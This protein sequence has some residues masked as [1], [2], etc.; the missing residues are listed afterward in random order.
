VKL[1][2]R[3]LERVEAAFTFLGINEVE[4]VLGDVTD[5]ISVEQAARGC[6]AT[7][8]CGSVY[9]LDPR[10]T[11]IINKTNVQGTDIVLKTAWKSGHDPIVHVSSVVALIGMKKAILSPATVPGT[12]PGVYFRSKTDSDRVARKYQNNIVPVVIT[13]PDSVWGHY[14]P[15]LGESC[16][17]V[18][19]ILHGYWLV[20]PKGIVWI[21]DVRDLARLHAV[22]MEKGR[23]PRRYIAHITKLN[24]LHKTEFCAMS[25]L[26]FGPQNQPDGLKVK[27][28]LSLTANSIS[29]V[30]SVC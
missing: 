29:L 25:L 6:D 28:V 15:H 5:Q 24:K 21:T 18:S 12:P 11:E 3:N 2:V 1:L 9:T 10:A 7:I 8:H 20:T 22:I 27:K 19:N 4:I 23:G 17:M 26:A 30:F 13:C 14:D 16:Q